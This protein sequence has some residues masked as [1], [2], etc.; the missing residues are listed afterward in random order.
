MTV[1]MPRVLQGPTPHPAYGSSSTF[2]VMKWLAKS[3]PYRH[4]LE[5]NLGW[6]T[7]DGGGSGSRRH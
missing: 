2:A 5:E 6:A 3:L 4:G 1:A 7:A